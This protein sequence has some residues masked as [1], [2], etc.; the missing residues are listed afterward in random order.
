[1]LSLFKNFNEFLCVP[2]FRA[3][4]KSAALIEKAM[5][6]KFV[7]QDFPSF[8]SKIKEIYEECKIKS[9]GEVIFS[10]E[11]LYTFDICTVLIGATFG[12]G[13]LGHK[14]N[15]CEHFKLLKWY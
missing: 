3:I 11:H 7:I 12:E 9:K 8:K 15:V 10:C 1:M 6:G 5:R 2:M 14:S 13:I 4:S